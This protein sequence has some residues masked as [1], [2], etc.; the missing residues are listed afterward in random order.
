MV[1][2]NAAPEESGAG[3][4]KSESSANIEVLL[5]KIQERPPVDLLF[6]KKV[7]CGGKDPVGRG[8]VES[9]PNPWIGGFRFD[10]GEPALMFQNVPMK[11][12]IWFGGSH[13][14]S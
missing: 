6:P 11:E 10:F 13:E 9:A 7:V 3:T 14:R 1:V 12:P 4:V 8:E 5:K 2:G